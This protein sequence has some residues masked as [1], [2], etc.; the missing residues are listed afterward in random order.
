MKTKFNQILFSSTPREVDETSIS[1][2]EKTTSEINEEGKIENKENPKII[3]TINVISS[4][5]D[6]QVFFDVIDKIKD[7]ETQRNYLQNLKNLILTE[8][9]NKT[10]EIKLTQYLM[11]EIFNRFKKIQD[12]IT[13]EDLKEQIQEVKKQIDQLKQENEQIKQENE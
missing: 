12:S 13:I 5:V 8:N 11:D 1:N 10:Q 4:K 6:K 9:S 3:K 2:I 7:E